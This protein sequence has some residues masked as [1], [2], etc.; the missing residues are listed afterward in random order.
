MWSLDYVGDK[1]RAIQN[2][3]DALQVN[4]KLILQTHTNKEL[5]KTILEKDNPHLIVDVN[6]TNGII[7]TKTKNL[8]TIFKLR[9]E[10]LKPINEKEYFAK[11]NPDSNIG[12]R[13]ESTALKSQ[14]TKK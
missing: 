14:Y 12:I 2:C 13:Y 3:C 11:Y 6:S 4:G 5:L 7:I 10:A 1:L 8:P 9:L